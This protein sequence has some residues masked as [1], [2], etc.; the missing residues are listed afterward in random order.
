MA[1]RMV[2]HALNGSALRRIERRHPPRKTGWCQMVLSGLATGAASTPWELPSW[3]RK[4]LK[5]RAFPLLILDGDG[6][7]RS[8]GGEGPDCH[9]P[10][11]RFWKCW[12]GANCKCLTDRMNQPDVYYVCKYTPVELL[13][14]FGAKCQIFN[15]MPEGFDKADQIA[16]PNTCA[17]LE[18]PFW[19][20]F[21]R[22]D[23]RELVLVNCCDT[24][25]SVYDV[26]L[27]SGRMDFLYLIDLLHH[28]S[29][30]SRE[31]TA[32]QL[33]GLA[34]AYGA[35][36]GTTFDKEAFLNAFSRRKSPSAKLAH[37]AV[38]GARMGE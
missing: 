16:H 31:R 20:R 6:C 29:S 5:N 7:D 15:H 36:K 14:A 28:P 24:I 21:L 17:D 8:H 2:Y 26:L 30:C 1:R 9:P 27:D 25:R 22:S 33:K 19:K 13:N 35:Y 23:I 32:A 10:R 4:N 37:L 34:K 11:R 18:K 3:Q 12:T 38:L